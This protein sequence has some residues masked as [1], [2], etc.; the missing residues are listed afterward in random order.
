M[1]CPEAWRVPH[2]PPFL[3]RRSRSRLSGVAL[4]GRHVNG[5]EID[6]EEM[7]MLRRLCDAAAAC[8]E[9]AALRARIEELQSQLAVQAGP[10]NAPN[11]A[12]K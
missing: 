9:G 6:P 2:A 4:Y 5:T 8:Y 3:S 11:Q 12:A 1:S 7:K 10:F